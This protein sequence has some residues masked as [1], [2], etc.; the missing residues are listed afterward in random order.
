MA[1]SQLKEM[2]FTP[3]V[4]VSDCGS[5]DDLKLLELMVCTSGK[6]IGRNAHNSTRKLRH[7]LFWRWH[8]SNQADLSCE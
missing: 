4:D 6:L 3:S 8:A 1:F 5:E 2:E 7:W